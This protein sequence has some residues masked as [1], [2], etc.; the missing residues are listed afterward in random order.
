MV[1]QRR[2]KRYT[3]S[4]IISELSE[5][6]R[7][8]MASDISCG[9]LVCPTVPPTEE[10]S[11]LLLEIEFPDGSVPLVVPGRVVRAGHGSDGMGVAVEFT[12]PQ[13][14]VERFALSMLPN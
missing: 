5:G 13:P 7:I 10:G 14:R 8:W 3:I 11:L 9:G 6:R 12:L 1:E 2:F 4:L